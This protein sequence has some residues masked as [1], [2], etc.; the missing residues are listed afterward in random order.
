[1]R[2]LWATLVSLTAGL[3]LWLAVPTYPTDPGPSTTAHSTPT[4]SLATTTT[5][6]VCLSD[7]IG[8]DHLGGAA[9][10]VEL[11]G[12]LGCAHHVTVVD[13]R[14]LS[15]VRTGALIARENGGPILHWPTDDRIGTVLTDLDPTRVTMVGQVPEEVIPSHLLSRSSRHP[16]RVVT[17]ADLPP[18]DGEAGMVVVGLDQTEATRSAGWALA[19]TLGWGFAVESNADL[20]GWSA[21]TR[22]GAGTGPVVVIGADPGQEWQLAVVRRNAELPGGGLLMFENRRLVALY[23]SPDFP[24]LGVMGEQPPPEAATRTREVATGYDADGVEVMLGFDL[25]AT[26]AAAGPTDDGDYSYDHPLDKIR[27]WIEEAERQG[28]YVVLDLQPGRADFLTQAKLYEEFLRLPHVGLA[29]DPEWRLGPDQVH[30][31]QIGTVDAAE[32]N[33]V[34]EWLAGIVRQEA[35]PQKVFMVHQFKLSMITNRDLIQTP[36]ELAVVIQMD[37]QGPLGSKYGT[38]DALL[39]AGPNQGWDWGW[40]NFYDEDS[41]MAT[42]EQV[43]DLDPV[44]VLITF[45]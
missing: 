21:E 44:P 32:I 28:F 39:A 10:V 25:I 37:G 23:G 34:S 45:Q 40:K 22:V 35:L 38:F 3:G 17:S 8:E 1:M 2:K 15:A 12:R 36:P 11:V 19:N 27:P 18:L 20:R 31:R 5:E 29:L 30:L 33:R 26:I 16:P 42:P 41:P 7:R 24:A 43:L 9:L 14:D 6:A 4:V 13:D